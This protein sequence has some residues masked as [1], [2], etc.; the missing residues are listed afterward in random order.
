MDSNLKAGLKMKHSVQLTALCAALALAGCGGGGGFYGSA[1]S[2]TTSTGT[3]G[4]TAAAAVNVSALSLYDTSGNLTH[5]ITVAGV[6]AK[7]KVTDASGKGIS[8][9]LVTFTG[10]GVTFGTTN[11]T[12]LTNANGEA[13]ISVKPTSASDTGSYQITAAATYGTG[14]ATTAAYNVTL[15]AASIAFANMAA[16]STSLDSGASTN[17]TLKTQD[18]TTKSNQNNVTVNFSASCGT[19]STPSVVS[20][21][22]GDVTTTYKAIDANGKLCAGTQTITA[23]GSDPSITQSVQVT[24]AAVSAN[25][26]VYSSANAVNLV[27]KNSGSAASGQ[28]Q[29]TVYS[30]G[31]AVANQD[32]TLELTKGPADL[33]FVTLGNRAIQTVKS[34][35]SGVVTVNLYPGSIPG[36][37][38]VKASLA[39]NASVSVLS[40]NV[41]VATG[42]AYQNGVSLSMSKNALRT[43][44]DGDKATVTA[45]LA[46]RN[47]NSVPDGTVVSFITEGGVI[48]PNC[49]TTAGVCTVTLTTQNPRPTDSRVSVLAYVEGDKAYTDVDG[50]NM[51]TVGVDTLLHNIGDAFRDDNENNVYDVS[52]GEFRYSRGASGATCAS[53]TPDQPNIDGTCD[54]NL[55]A[56]LRQQVLFAFASDTPT[57]VGVSGID[58]SMTTISS[59]TFSFKI[60][61]NT[62]LTVPMP[63]GTTVSVTTKDNTNNN[64]SCTADVL[65]GASTTAA[66][67]PLLTPSTFSQSTSTSVLY[68]IALHD[69]AGGDYI[70]INTAVPSGA[71]TTTTIIR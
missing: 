23:T 64:L 32:V 5:V 2:A 57:F 49:A 25:A 3:T 24:I 53:S 19:F 37:V 62:Q 44:I 63:S 40:K 47:G 36:P 71:S 70:Q 68:K 50:D 26:I 39:T 11:S 1:T 27:T 61:G 51:Y 58:S 42:R 33:S 15:Q 8:G 29:F 18:A 28:I 16:G 65:N 7:V 30:N 20:S 6:V 14:S 69:C 59:D 55:A 54:N 21:N 10:G 22:Q 46:D 31:T 48:T 38:E 66:V 35:S 13:S 9:A 41:A 43:D 34:D 52:L 45:R 56:V 17:I 60:F 12:V 4:T 67:I